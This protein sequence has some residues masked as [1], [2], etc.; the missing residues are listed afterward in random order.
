M[1]QP[2]DPLCRTDQAAGAPDVDLA[3]FG[4]GFGLA[5]RAMIG[6]DIGRA[7]LVARQI[8]NHLRNDI[9]G[10]LDPD[11]VADAESQPSDLVAVVK[12]DV[13]D[14]HA[15]DADR[16][17]TANR[18]Q[19]AS[20][21]DLDVDRLERGFGLFRRKFVGQ[22]PTRRSADLPQPLLPIEPSYLIN[23]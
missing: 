10:A 1:A 19:F 18:G 8:L 12:R 3:L 2:L 5:F 7:L 11:A 20:S 21:T 9:A 22:P 15:T 14:D 23:H 4:N 13:A 16:F 17:Q 6:K